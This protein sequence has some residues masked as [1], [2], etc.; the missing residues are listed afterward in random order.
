M[1]F[2]SPGC[3]R[4]RRIDTLSVT[5]QR[6]FESEELATNRSG[7]SGSKKR[8]NSKEIGASSEA[9]ALMDNV[10]DKLILLGK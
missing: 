10:Y 4:S 6:T 1:T 2:F 9:F 3:D 5:F 7:S 8:I